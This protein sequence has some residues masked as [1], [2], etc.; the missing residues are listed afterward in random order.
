MKHIYLIIF[1]A[2]IFSMSELISKEK[3]YGEISSE[4]LNQYSKELYQKKGCTVTKKGGFGPTDIRGVIIGYQCNRNVNIVEARKQYIECAEGLISRY[5]SNKEIRPYLHT[6][7]FNINNFGLSISYNDDIGEPVKA[8]NICHVFSGN[9]KIFFGITE[10]GDISN[11][12]YIHEEPYVE[13][14]EIVKKSLLK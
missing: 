2:L 10:D 13:S 12:E 7:P 6:F 8:P 5:N 11:L 9:E 1:I 14:L 4:I 3:K